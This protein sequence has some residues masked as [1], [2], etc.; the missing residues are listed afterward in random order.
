MPNHKKWP[1]PADAQ[2]AAVLAWRERNPEKYKEHGSRPR[3]IKPTK[4]C[5]VCE[6]EICHIYF[7]AHQET[8]RHC[9]KLEEKEKAE[10]EEKVEVDKLD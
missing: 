7:K 1:T 2:R 5:E 9:R 3:D 4:Y 6:K 10:K 8:F